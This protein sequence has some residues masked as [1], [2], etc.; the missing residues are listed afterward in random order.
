[1]KYLNSF[2]KNITKS[3][4]SMPFLYIGLGCLLIAFIF[5]NNQKGRFLSPLSNHFS[6]S[7]YESSIPNNNDGNGEPLIGNDLAM[8]QP[9]E[10]VN[11]QSNDLNPNELLP[12]NGSS[13]LN[14]QNFLMASAG[15]HMGVNTVGTSLRNANLQLRSEPPNPRT[16]VSPWMQTTITPDLERRPLED[17][18]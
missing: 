6:P 16:N 7:N 3:F 13:D 11:D 10:I 15:Q 1:M 14:N 4:N 5:Y 18:A 9:S 8:S 12:S 17:C 2:T